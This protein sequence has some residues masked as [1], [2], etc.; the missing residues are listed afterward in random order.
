MQRPTFVQLGQEQPYNDGVGHVSLWNG[1]IANYSH[2]TRAE[3]VANVATLSYGFEFSKYPQK[4]YKQLIKRGHLS[5]VEFVRDMRIG[6]GLE[7]SLRNE[8]FKPACGMG[9]ELTQ[10]YGNSW[11]DFQKSSFALFK[12]KAPKFAV[13]Q[14]MRHR[15]ASYLEL[16]RRYTKPSK[17]VFE[18]YNPEMCPDKD[19]HNQAC[20]DEYHRRLE[21]GEAPERARGAINF[22]VYSEFWVSMDYTSLG[23]F[24]HFRDDAHAQKEIRD[25]AT[26][27][28][29]LVC[30]HQPTLAQNVDV[31][32]NM[33]KEKTE[34]QFDR[35]IPAEWLEEK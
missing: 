31:Y 20:V 28:Y 5:C 3:V 8:D 4:L 35:L 10:E 12:I 7:S 13:I 27:M 25:L 18:F 24:L 14:Y 17:V 19:V 32:R 1:W 6:I 26:V 11:L 30:E 33:V 21:I 23:N 15:Q 22:D 34:S 29:K 16:S 2:D 9:E